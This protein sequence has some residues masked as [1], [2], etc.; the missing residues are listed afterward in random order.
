MDPFYDQ[1]T[2]RLNGKLGA[3]VFERSMGDLLRGD[4]PGLVP[5]SGGTDS[6]MDGAFLAEKGEAS[7]LICTTASDVI[8]NLTKNLNSRLSHGLPP[9]RVALATSRKLTPTRR[10]NLEER[11]QQNGFTLIQ[12]FDQEA[13]A[14]R[15]YHSP[16]WCKELLDLSGTP[17]ALSAVPLTR[18]PL[19]DLEPLGRESDLEWLRTTA[20]D[21]VLSGEPGSG[22]TFLPH[23]LIRTEGWDALFL[24]S[25]DKAEIANALREQR[26]QIIIV[27]DAHVDPDRLVSLVHL[28]REI[29]ASF[30]ILAITWEGGKEQVLEAFGGVVEDRKLELLRRADIL[31]IFHRMGVALNDDRLMRHLVDQAANKPGL[32]VTI[33]TLCR[34]GD[35]QEIVDG[36]ALSR[37]LLDFFHRF[38]GA[39]S[40]DIL[41]CFSLGGDRGMTLDTVRDYL[42]LNRAQI[43]QMTAGL[44]AGGVFTEVRSNVLAVWP[45]QLRFALLRSIFFPDSGPSHDYEELL[46]KAEN[47]SSAVETITA[48]KSYGARIGSTELRQLVER[49]GSLRAWRT[50]AELGPEDGEWVLQHYPGDILDVAGE[51][52]V[53]APEKTIRRLLDRAVSATGPI[54]SQPNHPMRIL[55]DWA[56]ELRVSEDEALERRRLLARIAQQYLLAGGDNSIGVHGICLALS[57]TLECTSLDPGAGKHVSVLSGLLAAE[58]LKEI[59][60]IWD[61]ARPAISELTPAAWE[62]I[63]TALWDWIYPDF[64]SRSED[65]PEEIEQLMQGFAARALQSLLP[66]TQSHPGLSAGLRDLASRVDVVLSLD[67]DLDFLKLF[68]DRAEGS[69]DWQRKEATELAAVGEL[70]AV[71]SGRRAA[72]VVAQIVRYEGEAGSI[73]RTWPRWTPVLC[74][75]LAEATGEPALWLS[76]MVE[77]EAPADLVNP[78]LEA[79]LKA[80]R[81]G[82]EAYVRSFLDNDRYVWI[83]LELILQLPDPPPDLLDEALRRILRFPQLVE[84]LCLG[85]LVPL[86]N[87]QALLRH[88]QWEVALAA[89]IGEWLSEPK[90]QVRVEIVADWRAAILRSRV[91]RPGGPTRAAQ[92]QPRLGDIL[93]SDPDLAVEWLL[94]RLTEPGRPSFVRERSPFAKALQSLDAARRGV[95][96]GSLGQEPLPR[97]LV[98]TLVGK[99]PN[100]YKELLSRRALANY[101]LEPLAGVPDEEWLEKATVAVEAGF[102]PRDI[103]GAAF[104][105]VGVQTWW[106]SESRHWSQWDQAFARFESD[107]REP[108]R[109]IARHGRR[110]AQ[111]RIQRAQEREHQ[112]ELQGLQ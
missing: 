58:K 54:H 83:A 70:A 30:R 15:L 27:D 109:E 50:L 55:A 35:W 23:Y 62:H 111:E 99:D 22:K 65:V 52:L 45:R 1:I 16:R 102:T 103:A 26:P 64:S 107:P 48:A 82:W 66:L 91:E 84:I 98:S 88:A 77:Q 60:A 28:R 63:S 49:S 32:A 44:A 68:P 47:L 51:A 40:A 18:R 42:G 94:A 95:V 73:S 6:G 69:E 87:L 81:S 11:A 89:A 2:H 10:R 33:A 14:D 4:L 24:V 21:L 43:R 56:R 5:V 72:D 20:G 71:W 36:S 78:F 31:E 9:G 108:V 38:V 110:I 74:R 12:I 92:F 80:H 112:E 29:K 19:T 100:L 34:Q 53:A 76:A 37:N 75:A 67:Q 86:A 13:L 25:D 61:E 90:G 41:A 101:H 106:G 85:N 79:T 104:R 96:L 59:E 105:I 8:G 7:P 97:A 39:H 93:A 17:P 3:D 46:G 57:P